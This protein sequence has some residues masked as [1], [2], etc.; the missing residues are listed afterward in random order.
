MTDQVQ[1][2]HGA[3]PWLPTP[4]SQLTLTLDYWNRPTLGLIR[5]LGC[6]F[7]FSVYGNSDGDVDLWLIVPLT[8]VERDVVI[9]A[10]GLALDSVVHD[11]LRGGAFTLLIT[12]EDSRVQLVEV[13]EEADLAA[14]GSP[15]GAIASAMRALVDRVTAG[16]DAAQEA[17]S[18]TA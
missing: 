12:D 9:A 3:Y 6:D 7:L 10:E 11:L 15:R 8:Q 18:G 4:G 13:I 17:V 2:L 5:Q 14:A 1:V 16:N